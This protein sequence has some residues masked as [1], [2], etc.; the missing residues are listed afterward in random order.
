MILKQV[1]FRDVD[2][3]L[4]AWTASGDRM[5]VPSQ[6]WLEISNALMRRYRVAG[7]KVIEFIHDLEEFGI[8]T[9][10]VDRPLVLLALDVA[11]RFGLTTYD[12]T[13]LALAE[14]VDATLFTSDRAL[15]VAAGARGLGLDAAGEYR[16]SETAAPYGESRP[17]WP[18]YSGASAFLAQL[19]AEARRPA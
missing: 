7:S 10:D 17:T 18:D 5:V 2:A 3:R 1:G 6:F 16:L 19:R 9:V 8:E 14:L 15:L 4:D 12:A 11:E 13:Y